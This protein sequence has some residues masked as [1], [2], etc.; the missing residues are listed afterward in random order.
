MGDPG[1]DPNSRESGFGAMNAHQ[2]G[3]AE[4]EILINFL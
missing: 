1:H 4:K 3:E 2:A